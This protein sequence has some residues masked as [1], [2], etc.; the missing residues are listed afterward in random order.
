VN[1]ESK[2]TELQA[3]SSNIACIALHSTS[4]TAHSALG[5]TLL[6]QS[7]STC[8]GVSG[9]LLQARLAPEAPAQAVEGGSILRLAADGGGSRACACVASL[10]KAVCRAACACVPCH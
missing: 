7:S 2:S 3:A 8:Q 6:V 5:A 4:L 1:R 9:V 10:G